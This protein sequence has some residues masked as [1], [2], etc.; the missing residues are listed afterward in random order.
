MTDRWIQTDRESVSLLLLTAHRSSL[1][2]MDSRG[3]E[4]FGDE[5]S[6]AKGRAEQG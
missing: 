1:S 5:R 3:E 6:E 2:R 4:S